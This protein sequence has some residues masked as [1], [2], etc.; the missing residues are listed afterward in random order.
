M[1]T[2]R[3]MHACNRPKKDKLHE[4]LESV[5]TVEGAGVS[6]NEVVESVKEKRAR[7]KM[8]TASLLTKPSKF[9]NYSLQ[10]HDKTEFAD[11]TPMAETRCTQKRLS[12][13]LELYEKDLEETDSRRI[14]HLPFG[15]VKPIRVGNLVM[16]LNEVR[17]NSCERGRIV[18]VYP[19]KN[20]RIRSADVKTTTGIF[21]SAA[22]N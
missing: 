4:M 11:S 14:W 3:V 1:L 16:V 2:R 19:A 13:D 20:G 10:K 15:E 12:R 22:V 18:K 17:R 21:T 8:E 5:F 9:H 6:A 7:E